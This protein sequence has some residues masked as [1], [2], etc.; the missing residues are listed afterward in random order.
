MVSA[1][2][3]IGAAALLLA[4]CLAA[5]R[6]LLTVVTVAGTSM[7]PTYR[8]GQRLLMARVPPAAI[9]VGSAIVFWG[10]VDDGG[11]DGVKRF[12]IVKRLAAEPGDLIP[13]L[14]LAAVDA[15]QGD[16]VPPGKLVVLSDSVTGAD[17]RSWGYLPAAAVAGVIL[18]SLRPSDY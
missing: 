4:S 18:G 6:L 7:E 8:Q 13:D 2:L 16:P 14:V 10:P 9:K 5:M 17:S 11:H 3:I 12:Y 1:A 15:R